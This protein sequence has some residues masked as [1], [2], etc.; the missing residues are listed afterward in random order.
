[1]T[2]RT[3]ATLFIHYEDRIG[4]ADRSGGRDA[5]IVRFIARKE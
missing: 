2:L 3:L 4:P 5:P 1:M